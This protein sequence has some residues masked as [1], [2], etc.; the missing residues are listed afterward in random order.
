MLTVINTWGKSMG[1]AAVRSLI[2]H[3]FGELL[4]GAR[5][6]LGA[7]VTSEHGE[8]CPCPTGAPFESGKQETHWNR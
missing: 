2:Q 7:R 5:Y 1:I 4:L 6:F 3:K 8:H